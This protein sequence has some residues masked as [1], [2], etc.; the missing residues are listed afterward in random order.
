MEFHEAVEYLKEGFE[1]ILT[2]GED[3]YE[4]AGAENFVGG[5]DY[6]GSYI[7]E[8]L[9]NVAYDDAERVLRESIDFLKKHGEGETVDISI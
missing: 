5:E 6:E 4:I 2:C 3:E 1:V 8:V 7:S 9:G